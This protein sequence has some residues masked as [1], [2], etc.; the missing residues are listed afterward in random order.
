MLIVEDE[1][2]LAEAYANWLRSEHE[3]IVAHSGPAAV[4]AFSPEVDIVLLD[5]RMPRMSGDEVLEVIDDRRV[6]CRIVMVTAVDPDFDIV[7]LPIDHYLVK[8][9]TR[10]ELIETVNDLL[11]LN[12]E[13]TVSHLYTIAAKLAALESTKSSRELERSDAYAKLRDEFRRLKAEAD[14]RL[15]PPSHGRMFRTLREP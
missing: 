8:P 13:D 10:G 12:Y 5:R 9:V 4:E 11:E 15:L 7:D 2:A 3:V 14:E 6:E 1:P